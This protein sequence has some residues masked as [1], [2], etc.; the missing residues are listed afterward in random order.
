MIRFYKEEVKKE[1]PEVKKE[2]KKK[3]EKPIEKTEA[4]KKEKQNDINLLEFDN[5]NSKSNNTTEMPS[6]AT[7]DLKEAKKD[8]INLFPE[9]ELKAEKK[10]EEPSMLKN[11]AKLYTEPSKVEPKVPVKE[12]TFSMN[13]M[14]LYSQSTNTSSVHHT[15]IMQHIMQYCTRY[16]ITP[17]QYLTIAQQIINSQP[18]MGQNSYQMSAPKQEAPHQKEKPKEDDRFGDILTG[19]NIQNKKADNNILSF[20]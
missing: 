5:P 4:V 2:E 20:D 18:I 15:Y 3:V 12:N 17:Q 6:W 13:I 9:E 16:N 1:E 19:L 10:S 8:D 11:L 7:D 14:S